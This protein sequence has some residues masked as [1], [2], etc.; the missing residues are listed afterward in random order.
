MVHGVP[1]T[2]CSD[3]GCDLELVDQ[4]AG[5][6]EREVLGPLDA[7][8][9]AEHARQVGML[10]RAIAT[11]ARTWLAVAG[12]RGRPRA[13]PVRDVDG[14]VPFVGPLFGAWPFGAGWTGGV[15][16]RASSSWTAWSQAT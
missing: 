13:P 16:W 4:L 5:L 1:G 9:V 15:W 11:T 3:R 6:G 8:L 10:A 7:V 12:F 2:P 14:P